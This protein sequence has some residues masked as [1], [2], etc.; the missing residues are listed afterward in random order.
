M[1]GRRKRAHRPP[2]HTQWARR[3]ERYRHRL[4]LGCCEGVAC[5]G[6]RYGCGLLL[7]GSSVGWGCGGGRWWSVGVWL[8]VSSTSGRVRARW[9]GLVCVVAWCGRGVGW[10][11]GGVRGRR[12]GPG[13]PRRRKRR[14]VRSPLGGARAGGRW[15]VWCGLGGVV[16]GVGSCRVGG[17]FPVP[18]DCFVMCGSVLSGGGRWGRLSCSAVLVLGA[19]VRGCE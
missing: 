16:W 8:V 15:R 1:R 2:S 11:V 10:C 14:A 13:H 7:R 17:V 12:R 5:G 6:A 19:G 3:R 4:L 9:C 18:C